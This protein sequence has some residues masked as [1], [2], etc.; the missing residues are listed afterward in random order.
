MSWSALDDELAES[1]RIW[2]ARL[3]K[4][5]LA[6]RERCAK[7]LEEWD[8]EPDVWAIASAIRKP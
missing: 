6:E 8:G 7:L 3:D 4:A 1:A 2:R 5:V